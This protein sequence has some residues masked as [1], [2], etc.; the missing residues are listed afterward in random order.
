MRYLLESLVANKIFEPALSE[1]GRGCEKDLDSHLTTFAVGSSVHSAFF[2]GL[3][4]TVNLFS[5]P[6]F[7]SLRTVIIVRRSKT[8]SRVSRFSLRL[9]FILD[10]LSYRT[11]CLRS[12][13]STF[14]LVRYLRQPTITE[15][16]HLAYP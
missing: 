10:S 6:V 13:W 16:L 7:S 5:F 2:S 9:F 3:D 1:D 11:S 14:S 12:R 4:D 15:K 8:S